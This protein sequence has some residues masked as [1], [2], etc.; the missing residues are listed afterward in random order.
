[1]LREPQALRLGDGVAAARDAELSVDGDRLGLDRVARDEELICDLAEREVGR[2]ERQQ[3]ELGRRKADVA[4]LGLRRDVDLQPELRG[5][6]T[7]RGEGRETAQQVEGLGEQ[8]LGYVEVAQRD[9]PVRELQP[10]PN[11][12]PGHCSRQEGDQLMPCRERLTRLVPATVSERHA[13]GGGAIDA[14][15][16]VAAYRRRGD[17]LVQLRG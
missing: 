16:E 3:P 1:M 12:E 14:A 2:E 9:E 7:Q 13:G 4:P 17:E 10:N 6:L 15:R 5:P 11:R 8:L